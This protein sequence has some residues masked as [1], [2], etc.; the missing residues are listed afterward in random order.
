V[1]KYYTYVLF[2]LDKPGKYQYDDLCFLYEPFYVGKGKD[3]RILAHN[4]KSY[5]KD[6]KNETKKELIE[7]LIKKYDY[8]DIPFIY[9]ANLSEE[10]SLNFEEE[11]IKKIGRCDLKLGPLTNLT[12]GNDGPSNMI[13]EKTRKKVCKLDYNTL[14]ILEIYDSISIASEKNNL[15]ISNISSCCRK[16]SVSTGGYKWCYYKENK[17]IEVK[18][19]YSITPVLM[20]STKYELLKEFKSIKDA[21][22]YVNNDNYTSITKSCIGKQRL[23]MGYIWEYKN[24]SD[25][26]RSKYRKMRDKL[27]NNKAVR[28]VF[29]DSGDEI[30]FDSINDCSRYLN[31]KP[32]MVNLICRGKNGKLANY[33]IYYVEDKQYDDI[34]EKHHNE[35]YKHNKPIL[36]Y[37]LNNILIKEWSSITEINRS[38]KF[39]NGRKY[40]RLCCQ[41]KIEKYK[42]YKWFYK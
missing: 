2:N 7:S 38:E 29:K 12:D 33:K 19:D 21:C 14:K 31:I 5:K 26:D 8:N 40:V 36:Q 34:I 20:Y 41:N 42:G 27:T 23:F 17:K 1:K 18:K 3:D 28:C 25:K 37:N 9:K 13:I 32:E 22:S 24:I 6:D 35:P 39:K 11:L 16:K 30:I 15:H 4:R 10:E